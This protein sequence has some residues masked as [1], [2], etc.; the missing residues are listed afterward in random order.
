[1]SWPPLLRLAQGACSRAGRSRVIPMYRLPVV[2]PSRTYTV[3]DIAAVGGGGGSRTRVRESSS[4]GISMRSLYF[5]FAQRNPYRQ[6]SR[7]T[8][9]C[10]FRPAPR[11]ASAGLAHLYGALAPPGGRSGQGVASR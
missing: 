10:R 3:T 6:G 1:M 5:A 11:G 4:S 8:S 9:P 7:Q 2:L